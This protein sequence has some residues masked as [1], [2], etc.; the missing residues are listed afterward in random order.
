MNG[1]Q[2]TTF[3]S[4][5]GQWVGWGVSECSVMQERSWVLPDQGEVASSLQSAVKSVS[6]HCDIWVVSPAEGA[7]LD[8]SDLLRQKPIQSFI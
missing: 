7:T 5:W 3:H 1:A 4:V 8:A 2:G 6:S